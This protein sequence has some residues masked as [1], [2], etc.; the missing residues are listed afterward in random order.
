MSDRGGLPHGIGGVLARIE[1][2]MLVSRESV[3]N[4][5]HLKYIRAYD[6]LLL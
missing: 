1:D 2:S 4:L 3:I 6:S 5:E